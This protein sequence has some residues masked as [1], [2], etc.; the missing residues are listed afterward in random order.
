M[1]ILLLTNNSQATDIL[2]WLGT[3]LSSL[4]LLPQVIKIIKTKN[5]SDISFLTMFILMVAQ[6]VW[7][8]YAIMIGSTQLCVANVIQCFF[9]TI[10]VILKTYK[11]IK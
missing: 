8:A 11:F 3:I 9:T 4:F 10:I 6:V 5:I 2:G 7:I 1:H